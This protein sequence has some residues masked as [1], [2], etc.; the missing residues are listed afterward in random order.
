MEKKK[1]ELLEELKSLRWL[2][3]QGTAET[4]DIRRMG[5]IDREIKE[6]EKKEKEESEDE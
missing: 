3:N 6:I 5:E 4:E 2:M 1:A